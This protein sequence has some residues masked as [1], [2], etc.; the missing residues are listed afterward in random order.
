M[1]EPKKPRSTSTS[2][3]RSRAKAKPAGEKKRR[4]EVQE[5]QIQVDDLTHV[6][7]SMTEENRE[8][9]LET[10]A[11][12]AASSTEETSDSTEV[13]ADDRDRAPARTSNSD[14]D[15]DD[16]D[17]R[18]QSY[19]EDRRPAAPSRREES[20][21]PLGP[22]DEYQFQVTFDRQSRKYLG[23][24]VE[25]SDVQV[26]ANTPE[27]AL[28]DVRMA[29]EDHIEF[30]RRRGENVQD[31]M[32]TKV[33]PPTLTVNISQ[34]LFRRLDQLSRSEKIPFEKLVAELLS[35]AVMKRFEP[36]R[37]PGAGARS[38]GSSQPQ[39]HSGQN[40]ESR[41]NNSRGHGGNSESGSYGNRRPGQHS[42][43]GRHGGGGGGHRGGGG[44]NSEM[45]E[46][47]ESFMEYVRNLEKGGH[48]K[49]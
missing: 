19:D 16:R 25:F 3:P 24:V 5:E 29:V 27:Q 33:Y 36:V 28:E 45:M 32:G 18:S 14:R 10:R 35:G 43:G 1:S 11:K 31:P 38:G 48:K 46:N 6:E 40:N 49:R 12:A 15:Y 21:Q 39:R 9:Q 26:F 42:Q 41:G 7:E 22:A 47:R 2:A 13:E 17:T 20:R 44:R 23:S 30:A 37:A 4:D 34:G 8:P